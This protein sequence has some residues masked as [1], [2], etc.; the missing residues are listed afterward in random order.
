MRGHAG[1][2]D[3]VVVVIIVVALVVVEKDRGQEGLLIR[4]VGHLSVELSVEIRHDGVCFFNSP[5]RK[6]KQNKIFFLF[7]I[8]KSIFLR[9]NNH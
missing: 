1:G 9:L 7:H 6:I 3:I 8:K 5:R 2:H 4:D